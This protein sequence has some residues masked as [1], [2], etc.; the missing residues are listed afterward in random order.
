MRDESDAPT[1]TPSGHTRPIDG[2]SLV[3][4]AARAT[5]ARVAP[6]ELEVFDSVA[7][8]WRG[9][10][11]RGGWSAPGGAVG[12][13]IESAL[14]TEILIQVAAAAIAEVFA[15]AAGRA[16]SG[17]Q[18]WRRRRRGEPL[19]STTVPE[20][21]GAE[22]D[23]R[24]R[25]ATHRHAI[26]LGLAAD[27]ADLLADALIGA[28]ASAPESTAAPAPAGTVAPPP[29]PAGAVAEPPAGAAPVIDP[30]APTPPAGDQP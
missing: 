27:Q 13:G 1:D 4:T 7:D 10:A 25:A 22:D 18:R 15:F 9:E 3:L 30:P 19:A 16:R 23:A 6:E 29:P 24:L 8:L 20:S 17:W 21:W 5:V 2:E 11:D 26:A 28:V 12:F 14:M